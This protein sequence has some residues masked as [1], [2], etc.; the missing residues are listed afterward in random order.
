[1]KCNICKQSWNISD[2]NDRVVR[3]CPFCGNEIKE[4]KKSIDSISDCLRYI[5]SEF[6]EQKLRDP[7]QVLSY[8]SDFLPSLMV[9]KRVLRIVLESGVYNS[10]FGVKDSPRDLEIETQKAIQILIDEYALSEIWAKTALEWLFQSMG[11]GFVENAAMQIS[12]NSSKL[13]E[14]NAS[15]VN[16]VDESIPNIATTSENDFWL[17]NNTIVR[18]NGNKSKIRIPQVINNTSITAIG[19]MAF[20]D[21]Q[22]SDVII[23]AGVRRIERGAFAGCEAL[24]YVLLPDTL[25]IIE[26]RAF[27]GCTGLKEVVLPSSICEIG[28]DAFMWCSSELQIKCRS[29]ANKYVIDYVI[30]HKW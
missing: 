15:A 17:Q 13:P 20:K 2:L 27:S 10:F 9:E 1:M 24:E 11:I 4:D 19:E 7:K 12:T 16:Y 6:G 8:V 5:I 21:S 25:E 23:P 22:I 30:N 29:D 18:Y 3:Y 14:E 26:E 28:T